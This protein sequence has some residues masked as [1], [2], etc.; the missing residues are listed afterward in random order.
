MIWIWRVIVFICYIIFTSITID[1]SQERGIPM[2]IAD[3]IK[4]RQAILR[5]TDRAMLAVKLQLCFFPFLCREPI[6]F[7]KIKVPDTVALK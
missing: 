3:I 6:R 5:N 2:N 1:T 4:D 7:D